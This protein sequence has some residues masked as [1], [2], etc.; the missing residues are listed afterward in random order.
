MQG[1]ADRA[2]SL[3][4]RVF[5]A[6]AV[7]DGGQ[8][9]GE[10]AAPLLLFFFRC[11]RVSTSSLLLHPVLLLEFPVAIRMSGLSFPRL[12]SLVLSSAFFLI[13]F[14]SLLFFLFF[15]VEPASSEGVCGSLPE[16]D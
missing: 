15:S 14:V 6:H 8:L 3:Q 16:A 13:L 2:S 10:G 11:P 9:C 12:S 5:L 7:M 4:P 1:E